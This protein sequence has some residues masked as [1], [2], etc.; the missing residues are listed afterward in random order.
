M[1]KAY[2]FIGDRIPSSK[3]EELAY[4]NFMLVNQLEFLDK[5]ISQI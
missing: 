5:E 2:F 1:K 3:N 4:I